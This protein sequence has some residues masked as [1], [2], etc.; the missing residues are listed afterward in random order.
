MKNAVRVLRQQQGWTQQ[1][2]GKRLGTSRQAIIAI[3]NEHFD[4]SLQLAI[5]ISRLFDRRVEEIFD[6]GE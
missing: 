2:L 4:P 1:E 5:K 3:E 6:L